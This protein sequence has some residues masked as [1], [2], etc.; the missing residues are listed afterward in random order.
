VI[1]DDRRVYLDAR[2]R[3][4]SA[5]SKIGEAIRYALTRW[6]GLTLFLADGR[7]DLDNNTVECSVRPLA[8]N[9]INDLFADAD[10]GGENRAVVATLV[11]CCKLKG[12]DPSA[13]LTDTLVRLA[14]RHP[15]N[16]VGELMP[17]IAVAKEQRLRTFQPLS[18]L[19]KGSDR[20]MSAMVHYRRR[21]RLLATCAFQHP[22]LVLSSTELRGGHHSRSKPLFLQLIFTYD[23]R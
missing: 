16:A 15:A 7:V 20:L 1:S 12:L 14:H 22:S 19:S 9:R 6:D 11:E 10:E 4:V 3:P 17:W 23:R 18:F 5:K 13:W 8:L 2:N 21:R